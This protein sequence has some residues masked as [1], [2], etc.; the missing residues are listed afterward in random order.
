MRRSKPIRPDIDMSIDE[1]EKISVSLVTTD[2]TCFD[3]T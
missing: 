3:E 1:S 2:K